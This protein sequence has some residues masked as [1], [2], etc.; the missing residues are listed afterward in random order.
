MLSG[1]AQSTIGNSRRASSATAFLEPAL[2]RPNLDVLIQTTVTRLVQSGR[3]DGKP[4]FKTVEFTTGP[5]G[6]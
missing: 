6:V 2:N 4:Q 1:W 5:N 3:K